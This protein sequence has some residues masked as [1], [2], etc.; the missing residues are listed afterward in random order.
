MPGIKQVQSML[1]VEGRGGEGEECDSKGDLTRGRWKREKRAGERNR[2]KVSVY[3]KG[4]RMKKGKG[5]G[6]GEEVN[7]E[8]VIKRENSM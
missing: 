8:R 2:R 6:E 1:G 5:E 4:Q 7:E 3:R